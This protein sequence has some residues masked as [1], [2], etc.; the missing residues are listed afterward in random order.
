MAAHYLKLNPSNTELLKNPLW[1]IPMPR[2]CD[3]SG[4][5]SEITPPGNAHNH[6][7]V[8]S[9]GLGRSYHFSSQRPLRR[10][11]STLSR[12]QLDFCDLLLMC[13]PLCTIRPPVN[14]PE[15]NL[16]F[17]FYCFQSSPTLPHCGIPRRFNTQMLAYKAKYGPAPTSTQRNLSNPT[18][19]SAP[20]SIIQHD[21]SSLTVQDRLK[22]WVTSFPQDWRP[23][24]LPNTQQLGNKSRKRKKE[25]TITVLWPIC[26]S[27]WIKAVL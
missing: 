26:S 23:A 21:P 14:D 2:S 27:M 12:R 11:F 24:S 7:S 9:A 4:E 20:T 8:P 5:V 19:C 15:S 18:L 10:W 25:V 3:F 16:F 17:Q 1:C 6:V 13:L 22:S